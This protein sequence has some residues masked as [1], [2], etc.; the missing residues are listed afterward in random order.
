MGRTSKL[1]YSFLLLSFLCPFYSHKVTLAFGDK[2][3]YFFP[4]SY[5]IKKNIEVG[6]KR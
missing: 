5:P 3:Q 6:R 4:L 1:F 2:S